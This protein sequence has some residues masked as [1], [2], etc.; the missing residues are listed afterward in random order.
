M[1]VPIE[2]M[3]NKSFRDAVEGSDETSH[4]DAR[5]ISN[6]RQSPKCPQGK[7]NKKTRLETKIFIKA[8]TRKA[9]SSDEV[10]H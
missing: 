10:V 3:Q 8:I 7:I 9:L 4:Q 6:A 2:L 5:V 1:H